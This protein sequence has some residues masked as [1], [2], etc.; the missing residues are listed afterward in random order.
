MADPADRRIGPPPASTT[1]RA[2]IFRRDTRGLPEDLLRQASKRLGVLCL[3]AAGIWVVGTILYHYVD[4]VLSQGDL[5]WLGFQPTDAL[6][7]L[8]IAMSLALFAYT[9]RSQRHPTFILDLG[10]IYLIATSFLV[11]VI[12]HWDAPSEHRS[13]APTISWLGVMVLLFSATL[14]NRP[15]KVLA[16]GLITVAMNPIGM[17]VAR[18]N[19]RWPFDHAYEAWI[20]HYPD[21]LIVGASV[22]TARVL[23]SL[24][25]Q[26]AKARELG[27]YQLG[28]LIGRGG[29]GEVYR[30][31]HRMLARSAAIKLIRPEATGHDGSNRDQ[32]SARFRREAEAAANLRSP[33]TVE[34]YDF[35]QTEDGTLYYAME[36]LDGLDLESIV[37]E[38][39]PLPAARVVHILRQVCESLE[40]AHAQGLVH[41]DIKPANIHLGRLGLLQDFAKVLDFGLVT[42][43]PERG[44]EHPDDPPLSSAVGVV[45]GTPAYMAPEMALGD[46]VD[47][48]ADIYALGCVAYY[49][50]TAHLVFEGGSSLQTIVK[51]LH[52]DPIPPS[53]RTDQ[54]IPAALEVLVLDCLAR[55]PDDRPATARVIR[56]RL[57]LVDV[58]AWTEEQAA[59][60]WQNRSSR[61]Q[62][63]RG[64]ADDRTT[65]LARQI[66]N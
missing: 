10:L 12:L 14:P 22:V 30:A 54:P 63:A 38:T 35:G 51:R 26:V 25:Q 3:L 55:R 43:P 19:G 46:V 40:E 50:L 48:R 61:A 11:G 9:R 28:D 62:T 7:A 23:T 58:N 41:R 37:R 57:A 49:L 39:G 42:A 16:T 52:E 31:R 36:L 20:M 18:A 13:M 59:A 5:D 17:L 32:L 15:L 64:A 66:E 8:G 53:R 65:M 27:S 29:M 33:H 6:V 21:L 45:R 56:E 1:P 2:G 47:R 34:L 60:W 24:G 44:A 4:R